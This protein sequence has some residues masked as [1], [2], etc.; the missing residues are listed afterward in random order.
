[1]RLVCSLVGLICFTETFYSVEN[2]LEDSEACRIEARLKL[3]KPVRLLSHKEKSA[4]GSYRDIPLAESPEAALSIRAS[5]VLEKQTGITVNRTGAP[6][7]QSFLGLRGSN[8]NQV[9]YFIEGLPIPKP[10]AAPLNLET[11]PLP[12]FRSVEVFSS[13]VPADLPS[14]NIGGALNFRLRQ[15]GRSHTF[16]Q[17]AASSLGAS[18][19]SA[20]RFSSDAIHFVA[21][22]QSRNRYTY[23]NDNGTRE[24]T[25]DDTKAIRTNEDFT[26]LGYTGFMRTEILGW[27]VATLLDFSRFD[28]GLPGTVGMPVFKTR[29]REE[30]IALS[31]KAERPFSEKHAIQVFGN[32]GAD[33]AVISDGDRELLDRVQEK[34]S[35]PQFIAGVGYSFSASYFAFGVYLRGDHQEILRNAE[36]LSKRSSAQAAA[37]ASLDTGVLRLA[38]QAS[39]IASADTAAANAFYASSAK[40]SFSE[41]VSSSAIAILRPLFFFKNGVTITDS[42]LDLYA[43]VTSAF[44]LPSLYERFGDNVFVTPSE[45]LR[46]ENALTNAVG[47]KASHPCPWNIVCSWRS[48]AWLTGAHDYILFTQN[49]PRTLM[50]VNASSAQIRGVENEAMASVAGIFYFALRYTWLDARDYGSIPYYRDKFLP[51]RPRHAV[52]VT[53]SAEKNQ[54][55][56]TASASWR[57]ALYRDRYNS[58]SYYLASKF[59]TDLGVDYTWETRAKHIFNFTIKNLTDNQEVDMIGYPVP[60]RYFLFKWTAEF[61]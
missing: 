8:P 60:G 32:V 3:K 53:A 14:V 9:D 41:G 45:K 2:C 17:I 48:E 58:Y 51:L 15:V 57:G 52:Q 18:S 46:N 33:H 7:T 31:F 29:R 59:T 5:D 54:W 37:T 30:R 23:P 34:Q 42:A 56:I 13:F 1:M 20:A 21:M 24:N 16:T 43:Q 36:F 22:E 4:A 19:V 10:Y 35:V 27:R 38:V 61:S 40:N 11:I 50:A 39:G 55:R 26:R 6:G 12:L 47:V 49:S 44:R 28:R 25:A